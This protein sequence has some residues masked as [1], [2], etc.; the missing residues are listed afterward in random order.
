VN[1]NVF[2]YTVDDAQLTAVGGQANVNQVINA[3]KV[4]GSGFELDIQAR[5]TPEFMV[6]YSLGYTD[7]EIKDD[8]LAVAGCGAPCTVTNPMGP[9]DGTFLID[10]NPL[11]QAPRITSS[12]IFE[13]TKTLDSGQFYI[14]GDWMYRSKINFVLYEAV[15]YR[16]QSLSEIGLRAGYRFGAGHHDL[17]VF[18]RNIADRTE[19][20]YTIDFNNLTGIVNEPRTWGVEY[21]WRY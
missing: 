11:P 14:N 3:N 6:Y 13:W 20:I 19:N 2:T 12:L 1:F 21:S 18:G 8:Q 5:V 7:T 15:E 10:G 4:Q 16:G 17:S 9:V